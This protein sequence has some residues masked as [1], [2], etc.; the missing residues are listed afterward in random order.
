L[1]ELVV[2]R[3]ILP[4]RLAGCGLSLISFGGESVNLLP[5]SLGLLDHPGL[6]AD[7]GLGPPSQF[8]TLPASG[9]EL[10]PEALGLLTKGIK[11]LFKSTPVVVTLLACLLLSRHGAG[12]LLAEHPLA[13]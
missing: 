1:P 9:L 3:S 6:L 13:V 12:L 5:P 2:L 8:I 11:L 7:E 4:L 10:D